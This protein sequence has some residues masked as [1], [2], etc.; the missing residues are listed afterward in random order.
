[1][2]DNQCRNGSVSIY[3]LKYRQIE[4][5]DNKVLKTA[6][7]SQAELKQLNLIFFYIISNLQFVA[8][9]NIIMGGPSKFQSKSYFVELYLVSRGMDL[10]KLCVYPNT[11]Q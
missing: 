7:I 11:S 8:V 2:L 9:Q 4:I 6:I 10:E 3:I 5:T 1:M